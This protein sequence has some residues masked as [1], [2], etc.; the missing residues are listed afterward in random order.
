MVPSIGAHPKQAEALAAPPRLLT[1]SPA[2]CLTPPRACLPPPPRRYEFKQIKAKDGAA[3]KLL[4]KK[5]MFRETDETVT[6]P[7]FVTLSYIQ[8]QHDY[9]QVGGAPR[10]AKPAAGMG[11]GG[12]W[13]RVGSGRGLQLAG[14]PGSGAR[15]KGGLWWV[16]GGRPAVRCR[17]SHASLADAPA[18]DGPVGPGLLGLLPPA[19]CAQPTH[20][21]T[22]CLPAPPRRASTL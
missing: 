11:E 2:R 16:A 6:E 1:H 15:G 21:G 7:Q 13:G 8:A 12:A 3:C 22:S 10:D 20:H 18:P 9:L 4:F 17:C 5:R 19:W 14:A